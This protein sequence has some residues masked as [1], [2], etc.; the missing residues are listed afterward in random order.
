MGY[1]LPL[2]RETACQMGEDC[3]IV[4]DQTCNELAAP[5]AETS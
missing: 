3:R 1:I 4:A 2:A 5:A